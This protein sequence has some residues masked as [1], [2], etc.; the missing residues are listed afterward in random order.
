M[1]NSSP[2]TNSSA[3]EGCTL[4]YLTKRFPRLSETFI[5]DE[6]IGLENEGLPLRLYSIGDPSE[7]L[8]QGEVAKVKSSVSYIYPPGGGTTSIRTAWA[9]ARSNASVLRRHPKNYLRTLIYVARKRRSMS[10][11][12]HLVEAGRLADLAEMDRSRHVHAAFA[13]GPA[14]VAHFVHLITGI[15]FSFSAHAKDIY[16]SAPD[17]LAR[18]MA[19]ASFVLVCSESAKA[20][21]EHIAAAHPVGGVRLKA[22]QH[23]H[24][25]PHGVNLDRFSSDRGKRP[26]RV[27]ILAVGR[28]VPKKGYPLLLEALAKVTSE[29]LDF[30]CKIVGGGALKDELIQRAIDLGIKDLVEFVGACT[31]SE[32]VEHYRESDLFVQASQVMA[33]GDRDGIPNSLMEAMASGLPV[34]AT[35]VGGIPEVVRDNI[36]GLICHN[37]ESEELAKALR[38]LIEN[39]DL[40]ETLGQNAKKQMSVEMSRTA[41]IAKVAKYFRASIDAQSPRSIAPQKTLTRPNLNPQDQVM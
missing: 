24:L 17:L 25:E 21:L 28:L 20:E 14:S 16:T 36:S 23:I 8:T 30:H 3:E 41:C 26:Q 39:P 13:H 12:K 6:I 32:I 9:I 38:Q 5:L 2:T 22:R 19:A 10:T 34:V 31:Q 40:R 35:S 37:N 33:D 11:V 4:T 7:K 15:P 29:N 18:K 27:Q 1:T